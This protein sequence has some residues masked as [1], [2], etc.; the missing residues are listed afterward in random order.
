MRSSVTRFL[1]SFAPM[2][3]PPFE[4]LWLAVLL[5][6][7]WCYLVV[8]HSQLL[9]GN[10][11]DPDD[12][13]YLVQVMDWLKGQPW[14]D[15]IQHRLNPP[16][17]VVIH[18]S[19]LAQLPMAALVLL[20]EH[21][22]LGL[23][24]SSIV[25]ALIYPLLLLALFFV[26]LRKVAE[27]FM[28]KS[29]A[30]LSAYVALFATPMMYMFQPGHVDHH[31]LMI[32][33]T[34]VALWAALRLTEQPA[35]AGWAVLTGAILALGQTLAL[36]I[37]PWMLLLAAW[38]GL[39]AV[40]KGREAG[41]SGLAF[42]LSLHLFSILCLLITRRP[43]DFFTQDLLT[44]SVVYVFLTG[45]IALCF[46]GVAAVGQAA[47]A[48]RALAGAL[49]A[50]LTGFLFLH[51]FPDLV[52]GPY[53]AMDPE[54]QALILNGVTE[55]MP[56]ADRFHSHLR[57]LTYLSFT[58]LGL[59]TGLY[60][61]SQAA[62]EKERWTWGLLLTLLLSAL[63]LTT[64]YQC[65]YGGTMAM[66]AIVPLVV[67]LQRGWLWI[68]A[69]YK[70]RQK[71]FAEIGLLLLV[72]P[73]PAVF[74]PALIDGRSFN[75]G[76]LLFPVTSNNENFCDT[77]ILEQVLRDS[78]NLGSHPRLIANEMGLGPEL[79]F[80]TSHRVLA[81]PF[82]DTWGNI[83]AYRFF[84]TPYAQEA[85][86]IARRRHIDVVV[87]CATIPLSY[88]RTSIDQPDSAVGR[89]FAPHFVESLIRNRAPKWLKRVQ[90][91]RLK[92]FAVYE[93]LPPGTPAAAT[94]A[95]TPTTETSPGN[96]AATDGAEK[97]APQP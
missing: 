4:G 71:V 89:D 53:G 47:L 88:L 67:F 25:M 20:F 75:T 41:R 72:G 97:T 69:H 77:Y 24:G 49:L 8:P 39:W 78:N 65:R 34:A 61:L 29:W 2:F 28:P 96:P 74:V 42:G 18:F 21:F 87:T 64:F 80:R 3:G 1:K 13:M 83:D 58:L 38:L 90:D 81:A 86:S 33:V 70:G 48:W 93:V 7:A 85:E 55:A 56:L 50:G 44:Y 46:A 10:F 23:R 15:N 22:G 63:L 59:G 19:R 95:V 36:E 66:L 27:S 52:T 57:L 5:Y 76:V 94:S 91:T 9:R 37:L 45:G 11:P 84:S 31:G 79:L 40:I 16:E 92:N 68:G 35:E 32:V 43:S 51:R 30:G 60:R 73:L 54:L 14:Y 82:L 62:S 17:G 6:F 26:A 12:Y